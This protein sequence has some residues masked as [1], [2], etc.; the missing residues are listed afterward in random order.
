MD[1]N[2]SQ[3]INGDVMIALL[4]IAQNWKQTNKFLSCWWQIDEIADDCC[5]LLDK[6]QCIP[7][8]FITGLDFA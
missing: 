4:Y 8:R 7:Q 2:S 1:I 6:V 3:I 5:M